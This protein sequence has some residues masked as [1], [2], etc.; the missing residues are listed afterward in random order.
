MGGVPAAGAPSV[1][2]AVLSAASAGSSG[3]SGS[4]G[5]VG[6][7]GDGSLPEAALP[8]LLMFTIVPV[9]ETP[10]ELMSMKLPPTFND[11]SVPASI[12]RVVPALM[13]TAEPAATI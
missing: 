10:E 1:V 5:A 11:N 3:S 2:P 9:I 6:E 8:P 4:S 7:V 12:T 13:W